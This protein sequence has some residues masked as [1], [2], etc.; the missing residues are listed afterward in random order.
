VHAGDLPR[1][2]TLLFRGRFVRRARRRKRFSAK[3]AK[4]TRRSQRKNFA[5]SRGADTFLTGVNDQGEIN[6]TSTDA[7]GNSHPFLLSSDLSTFTP[8]SVPGATSASSFHI[9]NLGEL[10]ILSDIG[11]FLYCSNNN[12]H[13]CSGAN[14]GAAS[15]QALGVR[16]PAF[17]SRPCAR[18][19]CFYPAG[20]PR[21]SFTPLG[22]FRTTAPNA[23]MKAS[24]RI[25]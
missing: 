14:A 20:P 18:N 2:F 12:D 25:Q 21:G 9:N 24:M 5:Q 4:D 15:V 11:G 7:D 19:G 3:V 1:S 16:H 10:V 8:I 23:R 6:G 17:M 22:L 13:R